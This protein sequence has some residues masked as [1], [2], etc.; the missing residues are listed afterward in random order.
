MNGKKA[1][2]ARKKAKELKGVFKVSDNAIYRAVKKA[3]TAGVIT[4]FCFIASADNLIL[5]SAGILPAEF[6]CRM[7][8]A[9]YEIVYNT[10]EV[11][12]KTFAFCEYEGT[13]YVIK[14]LKP[15]TEE[16]LMKITELWRLDG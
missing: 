11:T 16:E 10:L 9:G 2:L 3:I 1:K 15:V 6:K 14:T 12:D 7:A 13:K 8:Q 5:P 4:C